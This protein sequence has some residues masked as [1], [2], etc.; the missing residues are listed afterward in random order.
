MQFAE[1]QFYGTVVPEPST[2]A[3]LATGGVGL[4]LWGLRRRK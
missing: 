1:V 2:V 4:A 3:L